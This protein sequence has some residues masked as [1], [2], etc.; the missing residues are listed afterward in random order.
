MEGIDLDR[1][2]DRQ[3]VAHLQL[4]RAL[5]ELGEAPLRPVEPML[6]IRLGQA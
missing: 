5:Q 6:D 2:E 1:V 3:D 4:I